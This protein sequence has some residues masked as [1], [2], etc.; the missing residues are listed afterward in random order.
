MQGSGSVLATATHILKLE[1]YREDQH[2]PCARMT[3]K[4][5]KCST[6]LAILSD[7]AIGRTAREFAVKPTPAAGISCCNMVGG[8]KS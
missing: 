6:F 4:F 3:Q 1:R 8:R 5:V 7:H 2:G